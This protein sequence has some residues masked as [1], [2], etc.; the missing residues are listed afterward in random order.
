[1]QPQTNSVTSLCNQGDHAQ[2]L[3]VNI[4]EV[5]V[6]RPATPA[7]EFLQPYP[8]MGEVEMPLTASE[9][10][11]QDWHLREEQLAYER[12]AAL[13]RNANYDV[14]DN[15]QL[16]YWRR[17]RSQVTENAK[18]EFEVPQYYSERRLQ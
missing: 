15:E 18:S 16:Q 10:E 12:N 7:D 5:E 8:I 13:L 6:I 17:R 4:V 9:I 3:G 2:N 11:L 14:Y 1:M